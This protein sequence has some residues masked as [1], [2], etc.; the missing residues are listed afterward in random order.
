MIMKYGPVVQTPLNNSV[1]LGA[2]NTA[3]VTGRQKQDRSG[4]IM[5][6]T[7]TPTSLRNGYIGG[8]VMRDSD[9]RPL[10]FAP[11]QPYLSQF[12][13][14]RPS[15][16]RE[17][18]FRGLLGWMSSFQLTGIIGPTLFHLCRNGDTMWRT[19][20]LLLR[21]GMLETTKMNPHLHYGT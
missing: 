15:R 14:N 2:W 1:L 10:I 7:S 18:L 4:L 6:S 9:S 8:L 19:V 21:V 20:E 16:G 3:R 11:T 13:L 17:N 5:Q 12:S